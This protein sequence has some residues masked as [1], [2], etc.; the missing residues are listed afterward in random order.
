MDFPVLRLDD[1]PKFFFGGGD[2]AE[3]KTFFSKKSSRNG[4]KNDSNFVKLITWMNY[5][6]IF[7]HFRNIFF[8]KTGTTF[9]RFFLLRTPQENGC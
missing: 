9:G 3:I 7:G 5:Q 8:G 2:G 6:V 1:H 4:H